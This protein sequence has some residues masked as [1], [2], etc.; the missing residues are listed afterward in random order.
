MK[1]FILICFSLVYTFGYTVSNENISENNRAT[2]KVVEKRPFITSKMSNGHLYLQIPKSII[3]KSILLSRIDTKFH[4]Y[5]SKQIVFIKSAE[6]IIIEERMAWSET[7]IW[8]PLDVEIGLEKRILGILPIV[9]NEYDEDIF[10]INATNFFINSKVS[11]RW[12]SGNVNTSLSRI[13]SIK[14]LDQEHII[15][16]VISSVRRDNEYL[17]N[18]YYSFYNLQ[19]PMEPRGF[20][21]RM[22]FFHEDYN[23]DTKI[24]GGTKNYIA[25]ISRWKLKKKYPDQKVSIPIKPITFIIPPNIPKKWRPYVK[26]GIEEWLPAFEAAG[27][28]NAIVVRE[29]DSL[30]DWDNYSLSNSIIRWGNGSDN[31]RKYDVSGGGG[32]VSS[33]VDIRSGE[34]IKSDIFISSFNEGRVEKYFIRCAPLDIRALSYP[35]PETLQGETLQYVVAHEAG[36]SFGIKDASFGEY[37]YPVDKMGDTAWLKQM[38][39]TPTVMNYAR[40]NNIAQPKDSVP[41]LLLM[42]KVGPTDLYMIKWGYTEFPPN[43]SLEEKEVEL[44]NIIRLQ[45]SIPWYRYNH[46]PYE[47]VGPSATSEILETN[48]PVKSTQLALKNIERVMKILPQVNKEQ[49]DNAR[50]ERLYDKTLDLWYQHMRH[51]ISLIGGYEIFYKAMDQ[52]G[53]MYTPIPLESQEEA[54]GFIVEHA[55]DPPN[56][57]VNSDFLTGIKYSVYP[58]EIVSL[59]ERLLQELL[60]PQRMKRF[61]YMQTIDGYEEIANKYLSKLQSGLFRELYN[62][63]KVKPRNQEIQLKYI[64]ELT[65]RIEQESNFSEAS[66]KAWLHDAYTKGLMMQQLMFLKNDIEREIKKNKDSSS[67]GHWKLCLN[68]LN[69]VL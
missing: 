62:E 46:N 12:D 67:L 51:V 47:V 43:T 24:S 18:V 35:Y 15:K 66:K 56:W 65:S 10:S 44:E 59:Q 39:Y 54:L 11:W 48:D 57:L 36:H 34:I 68:K 16:T 40:Y 31:T 27:F 53:N 52:P 13:E 41:P 45:D 23:N 21:Y 61:E 55:F 26:A 9:K 32:T 20:D 4:Q 2:K 5:E 37:T 17:E 22:G 14:D 33:V 30:S 60:R 38:G 29:V 6:N 42:P 63:S 50:L 28:K 1:N 7:G 58:D 8:I 25:S 19:E 49:L 64:D 69:E 3:S